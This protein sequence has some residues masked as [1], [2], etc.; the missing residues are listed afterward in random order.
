MVVERKKGLA[1]CPLCDNEAVFVHYLGGVFI[2]CSCCE[3]MVAKQISVTTE[4]IL[5]FRDE[6]EALKVWNRRNGEMAEP[7]YMMDK[8]T[9]E[10]VM[11][12]R[13]ERVRKIVAVLKRRGRATPQELAEETGIHKSTINN[14]MAYIKKKYPQVKS[15]HGLPGYWWE[16]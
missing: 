13:D 7:K 2:K 9:P 1:P 5:P 14:T 16:D 3:C 4:T 10:E 6:E 11:R 12:A 15:K 8:A